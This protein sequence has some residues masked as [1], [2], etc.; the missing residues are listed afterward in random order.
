MPVSFKNYNSAVVMKLAFCK[1]SNSL[2]TTFIE[3]LMV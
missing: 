2:S 3:G 1:M